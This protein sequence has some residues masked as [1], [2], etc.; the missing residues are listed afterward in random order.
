MRADTH[1]G[2]AEIT[3]T[4]KDICE[5]FLDYKISARILPFQY[6]KI[7][8]VSQSIILILR[9]KSL[10]T[11]KIPSASTKGILLWRF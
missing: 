7:F 4:S 3:F 6:I 8:T 2:G 9:Q 1:F 5:Y 10:H 11:K